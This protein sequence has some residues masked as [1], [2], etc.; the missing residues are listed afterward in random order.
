MTFT[1]WYHDFIWLS[2]TWPGFSFL[3]P[4]RQIWELLPPR[5]TPIWL[6]DTVMKWKQSNAASISW[7]A[8]VPCAIKAVKSLDT[9][10]ATQHQWPAAVSTV[11]QTKRLTYTLIYAILLCKLSSWTQSVAQMLC[12][13]HCLS[14]LSG[15]GAYPSMHCTSDPVHPKQASIYIRP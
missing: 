10:G 1:A 13:F 6:I 9:H 4:N 2:V 14:C 11:T 15:Q 12:V 7:K 3:R 5:Q 8:D